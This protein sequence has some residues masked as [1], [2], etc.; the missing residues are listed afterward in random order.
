MG[1]ISHRNNIE[2]DIFMSEDIKESGLQGGKVIGDKLSLFSFI[3]GI[4]LLI[5]GLYGLLSIIFN[6]D[7]PINLANVILIIILVSIGLLMIIGGC[8]IRKNK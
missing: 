2:R 7:F 8:I 4:P 6:V 3:I 5:I 1:N